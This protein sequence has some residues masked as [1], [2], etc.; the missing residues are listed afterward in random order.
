MVGLEI[1]DGLMVVVGNIWDSGGRDFY[2]EV[3]SGGGW[4]WFVGL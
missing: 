1:E 3:G 2:V 4:I